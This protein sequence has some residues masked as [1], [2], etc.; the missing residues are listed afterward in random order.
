MESSLY[1]VLAL[2]MRYWFIIVILYIVWRIAENA[3][4]E[5]RAHK[6]VKKEI[7]KQFYGE[8]V[9]SQSDVKELIGKRFG[10]KKENVFGRSKFCDIIIPSR[11][12]EA[13]HGMITLRGKK[14]MLVD[15]SSQKGVMLNGEAVVKH[16]DLTDGD[17]I[18]AGK[19]VLFI[20]LE[21]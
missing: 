4:S 8:I 5:Y 12:M 1:E 21:G 7:D 9:I 15:L 13:S 16:A 6:K 10:I 17:E 3:L 14:L 20:D 19:T 2:I 18:S 11:S